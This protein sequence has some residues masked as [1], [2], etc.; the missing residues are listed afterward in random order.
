LKEIN[1]LF[2]KSLFRKQNLYLAYILFNLFDI[3]NPLLF[4]NYFLVKYFHRQ[5]SLEQGWKEKMSTGIFCW[6][7]LTELFPSNIF[8]YKKIWDMNVSSI[9]ENICQM[10]NAFAF[11]T[12][13]QDGKKEKQTYKLI[14]IWCKSLYIFFQYILFFF[15]L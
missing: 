8:I 9:Y 6:K 4:K 15:L 2:S 7:Y 5:I 3:T 13:R 12:R 10:V 1:K 14:V 11:E